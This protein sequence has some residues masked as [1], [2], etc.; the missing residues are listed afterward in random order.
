MNAT[1]D[2]YSLSLKEG[3][4]P[5]WLAANPAAYV[6]MLA[7]ALGGGF[8]AP[9]Q[10]TNA[11]P[12]TNDVAQAEEMVPA[13]D[14]GQT[15]GLNPGDEMVDTNNVAE[16][17]NQATGPGE[18]ARSRRLRRQRQ[19]SARGY[20]Q[21]NGN[22]QNG[23]S[24]TNNG[25]ASLDYSAFRMVAERNIFDPNRTPHNIVDRPQRKTI[26]SFSLVGTMS[27]EK[28]DF[29]FFDGPSSDYQKVLKASDTIAGYKVLAVL[30]DSVTLARATNELV[31]AVGAQ[32]RRQDDGTWVQA[33]GGAAYDASPAGS[34]STAQPETAAS[35]AESDIIKRMMQRREK[36]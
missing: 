13:N 31:L 8:L 2:T 19:N 17:N 32:L 34:N 4:G 23:A 16:T 33:A 27:Y 28:G 5:A 26:E 7:L 6:V 3:S 9:A 18:D 12:A 22:L 25:P 24:A 15:E 20:G 11:P 21:T 30:P 36:E 35:G 14:N 1:R 10:D 29:A